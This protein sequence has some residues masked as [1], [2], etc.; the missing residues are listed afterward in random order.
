MKILF[1]MISYPDIKENSSMYTDLTKEFSSKGYEVYVAVANGPRKTFLNIEGGITVLRVRTLELFNTSIINKGLA[2]VLLP[3]QVTNGI[4]KYLKGI[5]FDAVIVPTPPITYLTTVARLKKKFKSKVY[6][7]LRDIFPQNAK[8][9]GIIKSTIIFEYFRGN[10]K[11]LYT[12][13]DF[14]GCMSPR[15]IEYV[16]EHNPGVNRQKLHLLPNWE[17][18]VEYD[19]PDPFLKRQLGLENRFIV[20]YGGNF[21]KPQQI[22]FILDLAKELCHLEDVVFLFIGVGSEKQSIINLAAKRKLFNII[23]KDSLPRDQYRE[24]VKICDVGLVNI[25][26]KFT[27]PNIPSR[28]LSYWEAKIP[29]LAAIDKNTDFGNIIDQ[30]GSGLWSISG[31][32]AAYKQNFE[33]LYSDKELR[34]SMGENGYKY[35][36]E[37]CTTSHAFSIIYDK[38]TS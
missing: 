1:L 35:L 30:S 31:D 2:N 3:F 33:K 38:L 25:S 15:N 17:N 32:M 10:E 18:V 20:L 14:I 6:L 9:L 34:N 26:N 36:K 7:V 27:I 28:T 19:Q 5:S 22:D 12:I 21:G 13:S 24:L 4:T 37:N 11:K 29:V 16:T 23:F 8:D